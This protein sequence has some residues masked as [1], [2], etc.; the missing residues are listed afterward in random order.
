MTVDAR[1]LEVA[2]GNARTLPVAGPFALTVPGVL[3][4]RVRPGQ[5]DRGRVDAVHDAGRTLAEAC[6][7][8]DVA[9][10]AAARRAHRDALDAARAADE[11]RAAI[12]RELAGRDADDVRAA[13]DA[14][15]VRVGSPRGPD[16][17]ALRPAAV[18]ARRAAE[19][20]AARADDADRRRREADEAVRE[21]ET[22]SAVLAERAADA[23]HAHER[24]SAELAAA[25]E[26]E[27]DDVLHTAETQR[28]DRA[29]E[30]ERAHESLAAAVAE[31]DPETVEVRVLNARAV[32]ERY[33][34]DAARLEREHAETTGRLQA[35]GHQGWH[36]QLV[37]AADEL[38]EA[39]RDHDA[40]ARRAAAARRLH[41][42]L[43]RHR[44]AVRRSYVAPF[45]AQV[46]RLARIVFGPTLALEIDPTLRITHRT[47]EGV[48]VPF[49]ALS[50]GAKEQLGLCARLACAALVDRSDG[51]PVVIDDALGHSDP[52]RLARLGA[53][54]TAATAGGSA[55]QVVVLTC[56]PERYH[57][58]GAATV[59]A[60]G[61][62]RAPVD[63][64]STGGQEQAALTLLT[65]E[66]RAG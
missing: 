22:W 7:A 21:A 34:A 18:A 6:A 15:R 36:D 58:V 35:A 39:Q 49:D 66:Q 45:R 14:L 62:S 23:R 16:P 28:R 19:D 30:A 53:V 48:T 17:T 24:R 54:F 55:A 61:P 37:A 52:D 33:V 38:A 26:A 40:T 47:L 27:P 3:A 43:V 8:L 56:S 20:A 63:R 60:L 42:T 2:P 41:E 13:R 25:R 4:V 11:H 31:T 64:A 12:D 44:D 59:V 51:V 65:R 57:G 9:D 50:T 29:R 32:D 46:E 1:S 10:L 5:D